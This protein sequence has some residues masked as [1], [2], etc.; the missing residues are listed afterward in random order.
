MKARVKT[1]I[2]IDAGP[3]KVFKYIA[4]THYH[5]QW[6]PL[7]VKIKPLQQLKLGSVYET[8]T[9]ALGVRTNAVNHVTTFVQDEEI[10]FQN[11]TGM[12]Q[13][14]ANFR[15]VPNKGMTTLTCNTVVSTDSK[16]FAFAKPLLEHIARRDLKVDLAALKNAAEQ[17][18]EPTE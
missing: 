10:E 17:K 5:R 4:D 8:Q 12:L 11:K 2:T 1:S 9:L 18:L 14:C 15:L 3:E 6:S 13:Y 16:C 7:L